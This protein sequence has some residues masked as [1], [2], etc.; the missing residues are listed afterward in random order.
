M[1]KHRNDSY[2][3]KRMAMENH[4]RSTTRV[5]DFPGKE[6]DV[7]KYLKKEFAY[8]VANV[9]YTIL[10]DPLVYGHVLCK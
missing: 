10:F 9:R 8:D 5:P 6:S 4:L 3:W 1:E 2:E 7:V